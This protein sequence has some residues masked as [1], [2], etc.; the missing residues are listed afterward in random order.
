MSN[1][2]VAEYLMAPNQFGIV[3]GQIRGD[4]Y[5]HN[6]GWYNRLGDKI[7]WGDLTE[8]DLS[9]LAGEMNEDETFI[10]LSEADSYWNLRNGERPELSPGLDY[11]AVR[12]KLVIHAG[13]VSGLGYYFKPY[14]RMTTEELRRILIPD[15]SKL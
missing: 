2:L 10:V 9:H 14:P 8:M 4:E 12:A 1:R 11:V 13:K 7:G 5:V 3:S 6:G 15:E